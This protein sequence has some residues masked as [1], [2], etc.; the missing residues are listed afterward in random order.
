MILNPG[1]CHWNGN[2]TL[3]AGYILDDL[4]FDAHITV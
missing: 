1:K 4:K 3:L 2:E